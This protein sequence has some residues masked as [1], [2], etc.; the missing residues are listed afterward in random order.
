MKIFWKIPAVN[1]SKS[2]FW[3]VICI[4]K[5]IIW[6]T[7]KAIFS[8]FRFLC[9][10]RFSNSSISDKYC[11]ILTNHTAMKILCIILGL[12]LEEVLLGIMD[13]Y[14]GK[15]RQFEVKTHWC[16]CSLQTTFC[17]FSF[18]KIIDGLESCGLLLSLLWWLRCLDS[19]SDGTH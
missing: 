5:N 3:L 1:V 2:K 6:T 13:L 12:S 17:S 9:T 7:L 10:L 8:I 16:I 18:H 15:K 11:P 14:F 4:A 19:H